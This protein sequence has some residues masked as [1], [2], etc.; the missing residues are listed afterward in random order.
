MSPRPHFAHG[1]AHTGDGEQGPYS[2]TVRAL[3]FTLIFAFLGHFTTGIPGWDMRT[4]F[5][6]VRALTPTLTFAS[7]AF[8]GDPYLQKTALFRHQNY[9]Q[10]FA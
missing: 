2:I 5:I 8:S 4:R 3:T 7:P 6:T 10:R 9:P 1:E